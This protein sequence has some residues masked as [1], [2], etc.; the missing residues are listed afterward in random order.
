[1]H[2]S[3]RHRTSIKNTWQ[4]NRYFNIDFNSNG[5][6]FLFICRSE[7]CIQFT[8]KQ[9]HFSRKT[10]GFPQITGISWIY[11]LQNGF[12][13]CLYL[14]DMYTTLKGV[15]KILFVLVLKT[16]L[17]CKFLNFTTVFTRKT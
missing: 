10:F 15:G 14:K 17:I 4:Y 8:K 7:N 2:C 13:N 3:C 16:L 9:K 1:M 6:L 5:L 12:L 11:L